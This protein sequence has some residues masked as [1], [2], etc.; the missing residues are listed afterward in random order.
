M[1][2]VL[3]VLFALGALG[4]AYHG[5]MLLEGRAYIN[6]GVLYFAAAAVMLIAADLRRPQSRATQ[7]P[8]AAAARCGSRRNLY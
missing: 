5:Q 2:A 7:P 4:V 1:W 8:T 3:R 6:Q